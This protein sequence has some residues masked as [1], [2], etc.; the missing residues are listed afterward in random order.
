M[1]PM[2]RTLL[3]ALAAAP[4]A[5][6]GC[7]SRGQAAASPPPAAAAAPDHPENIS[8]AHPYCMWVRETGQL[9]E[10]FQFAFGRCE[11]WGGRCHTPG[12]IPTSDARGAGAT[13]GAGG[14]SPGAAP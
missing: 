5:L 2:T 9:S 3:A 14:A 11:V 7:A 4:L 13:S 6:A 8:P 12:W 1:N 10:C